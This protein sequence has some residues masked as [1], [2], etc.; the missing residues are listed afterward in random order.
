ME[1]TCRRENRGLDVGR[2]QSCSSGGQVALVALLAIV[3]FIV[4]LIIGRTLI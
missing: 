1:M 4:V 2:N 3:S